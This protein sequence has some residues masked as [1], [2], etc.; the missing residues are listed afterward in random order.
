MSAHISIFISIVSIL[1]SI[2]HS[3]A[4][5]L[6]LNYF[7][8]RDDGYDNGY[9]ERA[10]LESKEG[11]GGAIGIAMRADG[12]GASIGSAA[13]I[14]GNVSVDGPI[15]LILDGV[16]EIRSELIPILST[17][18]TCTQHI[19]VLLTTSR[20]E[21]QWGTARICLTN[22][23]HASKTPTV[24]H[25]RYSPSRHCHH[26][27]LPP[28]LFSPLQPVI[29]PKTRPMSSTHSGSNT[30]TNVRQID[31]AM[32]LPLHGSGD[33]I[34]TNMDAG[35]VVGAGVGTNIGTDVGRGY[36]VHGNH[37]NPAVVQIQR[38]QQH[39]DPSNVHLTESSRQKLTC[40]DDTRGGGG[41]GGGVSGSTGESVSVERLENAPE[42]IIY[43]VLF[44][45]ISYPATSSELTPP[46]LHLPN[47]SRQI[48][49]IACSVPALEP[50]FAAEL[51]VR[52]AP[53][54]LLLSG[55]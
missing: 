46:W 12:G 5:L 17:I 31:S 32:P 55:K 38:E 3:P 37:P 1:V 48:A 40:A 20:Y 11:G 13:Q 42:K 4:L 41:G 50:V 28:P 24:L 21:A 26:P 14:V 39:A 18:F 44:D 23:V 30:N 25:S 49:P 29:E 53:R 6:A 16:D 34:H 7:P 36:P 19:H 43:G 9:D 8:R 27:S 2:S 51:L 22:G 35:A 33:S 10:T 54:R 47:P 15:L 52:L 45:S